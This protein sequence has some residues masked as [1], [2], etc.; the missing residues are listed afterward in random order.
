TPIRESKIT[1]AHLV[2]LT[3][4]VA[5]GT[6]NGKTAKEI[7]AESYKTGERPKALVAAKGATQI[8]DES[9]IRE[10]IQGILDANPEVVAKYRSGQQN[11]KGFLVGQAMKATAGRANP[12]LVQQ[13]LSLQLEES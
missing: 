13:L 5:D 3:N 4:L 11:V 10:V 8:T 7:F 12:N 2:E 1:P 6:I 9:A